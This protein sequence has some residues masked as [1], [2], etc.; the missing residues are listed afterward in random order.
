MHHH[1]LTLENEWQY[2]NKKSQRPTPYTNVFCC[3]RT[4][5][6]L[7][8]STHPHHE[9][10]LLRHFYY[11]SYNRIVTNLLYRADLLKCESHILWEFWWDV[12]IM[13]HSH[14]MSIVLF[15]RLRAIEVNQRVLLIRVLLHW[16]H[17]LLLWV[18]SA[19]VW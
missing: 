1:Q 2:C 11:R 18:I 6:W 17:T 5:T 19:V 14:N 9:A 10:K 3:Q 16:D 8:P 15:I 4:N 13:E 12:N 7:H